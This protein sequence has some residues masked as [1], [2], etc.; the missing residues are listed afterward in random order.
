VGVAEEAQTERRAED[1]THWLM[2]QTGRG[3]EYA[4]RKLE[5]LSVTGENQED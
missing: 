1:N 2:I 4:E 3:Y 5:R